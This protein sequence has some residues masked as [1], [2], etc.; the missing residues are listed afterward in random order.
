MKTNS[1]YDQ[2]LEAARLLDYTLHH[3]DGS[4]R[5]EGGGKLSRELGAHGGEL[6]DSMTYWRL[7]H[8]RCLRDEK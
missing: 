3:R 2:H 8:S 7:R 6:C 4:T 1:I 5:R